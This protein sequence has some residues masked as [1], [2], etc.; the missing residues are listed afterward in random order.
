MDRTFEAQLMA[1]GEW[2]SVDRR[3]AAQARSISRSWLSSPSSASSL[4][5]ATEPQDMAAVGAG[6]RAAAHRGTSDPRSGGECQ[7]RRACRRTA[8]S[9]ARARSAPA[10]LE[11]LIQSRLR[12]P[13]SRAVLQLLS[14][15]SAPS[16]IAT[17]PLVVVHASEQRGYDAESG[18][19][20]R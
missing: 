3:F 13:A 14:E 2:L 1:E 19:S 18:R 12:A 6:A 11:R 10:G 15:A 20:A 8:R 7:R 9:A 4:R 16:Q 5:A 17:L